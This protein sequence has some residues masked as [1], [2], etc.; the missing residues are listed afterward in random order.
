MRVDAIHSP[1]KKV[2]ERVGF[3]P[4]VR[5]GRTTAFEAAAFNHSATSPD[6]NLLHARTADRNKRFG[7][8]SNSAE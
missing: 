8:S 7:D 2:A 5:Q 3:E 4:T 1:T 6:I